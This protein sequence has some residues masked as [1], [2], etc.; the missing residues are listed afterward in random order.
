MTPAQRD[1]ELKKGIDPNAPAPRNADGS[2]NL[3]PISKEVNESIGFQPD[4]L[5][6]IVSLVHYR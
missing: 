2:I 1:A 5:N 4:E 3:N 6:R